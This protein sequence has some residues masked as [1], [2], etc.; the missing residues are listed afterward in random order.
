MGCRKN[1]NKLSPD[2][3]SR[4]VNAF[5]ALMDNGIAQDYANIHSGAGGHGHGGPAFF[6]W[7][8]EFVRRFELDLQAIDPSVSIPYWDWTS[9]NLNSSG[10]ES[11]IWRDDFMGGPGNPI[12]TGP[13]AGRF[14]RGN[15]NIFSFPGGGGTIANRMT[16][17]NY[18]TFRQIEGPHGSA[19]VFIGGDVVSFATTSGTPDFWLIHCNVDRLWSEWIRQHESTSGFEPYLPLSGGPTG[20][21]IN[22]TMWPWNGTSTPFGVLPWTNSPVSVMPVDLLDHLAL[23][24]EYDTID[25]CGSI[26]PKLLFREI[27]PRKVLRPEVNKRIKEFLPKERAPKELKEFNPKES[28]PKEIIEG[29]FIDPRLRPDLTTAGLAFEPDV[30]TSE[31]DMLRENMLS[32][33][34]NLFRR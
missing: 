20:H 4:F 22:D 19:H 6:P 1:L 27:L 12:T 24:Y 2:E 33:R 17:S 7:H 34:A 30:N 15:F 14:A 5:K 28:G 11:L 29:P 8:R 10:T 31:L 25:S 26:G 9:A 23:G 3:R 16:S 21:S 13:F 32:R 18:T